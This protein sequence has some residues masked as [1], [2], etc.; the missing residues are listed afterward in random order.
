M[1]GFDSPEL[2]G[3]DDFPPGPPTAPEAIEAHLAEVYGPGR[4][5]C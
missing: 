4:R 2:M 1:T 5:A 3:P